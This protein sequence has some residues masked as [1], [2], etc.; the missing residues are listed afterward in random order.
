MLGISKVSLLRA[1]METVITLSAVLLLHL[2]CRE[3][4]NIKEKK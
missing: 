4:N 2:L 1:K 3:K